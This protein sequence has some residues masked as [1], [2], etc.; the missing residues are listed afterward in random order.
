[1]NKPFPE[2]G[3]SNAPRGPIPKIAL[4]NAVE[5]NLTLRE[6]MM[7][8]DRSMGTVRHWLKKYN[9]DVVRAW[10][11]GEKRAAREAGDRHA[12]LNCR[13]HGRTRFVLEGRGYF[14]CMKCRQARVAEQRRKNKETLVREAGGRCALCGYDRYLGALEFHHKDRREKSFALSSRGCT[15]AISVL[16]AEAAKCVLLCAN[17]HAE[18]ESGVAEVPA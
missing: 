9:L 2:I 17:C 14:R 18:V 16:R 12:I 6:M 3:C 10:R 5:R 11:L 1:M 7:E 8:F 13:H 15:R 4:K